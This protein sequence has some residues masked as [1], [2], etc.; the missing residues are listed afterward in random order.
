MKPALLLAATLL[1]FLL[2][3]HPATAVSDRTRS[4][5]Q[6]ACQERQLAVLD[7]CSLSRNAADPA[8][9]LARSRD[10]RFHKS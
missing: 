2:G 10:G 4:S 9:S 6:E 7:K 8:P 3:W 1:A 5:W